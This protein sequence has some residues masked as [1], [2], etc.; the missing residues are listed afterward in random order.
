[1][2]SAEGRPFC[3]GINVLTRPS[4]NGRRFADDIF[5]RNFLNQNINPLIKNLLGYIPGWPINNKLKQKV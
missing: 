2:S 3:L 4:Q 1:M 5:K